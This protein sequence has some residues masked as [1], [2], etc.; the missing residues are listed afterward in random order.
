MPSY[1]DHLEL[2]MMIRSATKHKYPLGKEWVEMTLYIKKATSGQQSKQVAS[3]EAEVDE[4]IEEE[5]QVETS[6]H[7]NSRS[8]PGWF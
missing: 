7:H 3:F 1:D 6:Q 4:F 5:H 2:E 8:H